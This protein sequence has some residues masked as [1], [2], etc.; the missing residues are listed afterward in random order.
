MTPVRVSVIADVHANAA[1]LD[2]VLE[3]VARSATER[4]VCL[5][6][7]VGYN[8]E[9][10]QC[11][12][13][14]RAAAA[15]V[16]AGN[17]DVDVARGSTCAGTNAGARAA[18]EWTRAQLDGAERAWLGALP[19]IACDRAGFTAVHGCYL[20]S[21]YYTGYVTTT[22][23]PANLRAAAARPERPRVALC[24]HTHVPMLGW[25]DGDEC[26]EPRWAGTLRWPASAAAVLV[27]PGSVG[28]PRDGDPR[29]SFA[30]LDLEARTAELRRVAYDVER[31]AR[32]I[33]AAG[34][35]E[36]LAARLREGR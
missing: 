18:Q 12:A 4:L 6:D 16:V 27:N 17:H 1:A 23:L 34:L 20:N 29:A 5:G 7:L 33:V 3:A 13:R 8:A 36:T 11:V 2:A 35:P 24:G 25:L 14:L 19:A 9:P 26:A 28:Q 10:A 31:A 15:V 22:M 21:T 32:A 30:I